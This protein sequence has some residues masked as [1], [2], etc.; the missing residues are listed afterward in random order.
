MISPPS[1]AAVPD[2]S[3]EVLEFLRVDFGLRSPAF[4]RQVLDTVHQW[5]EQHEVRAL[6]PRSETARMLIADG[7]DYLRTYSVRNLGAWQAYVTARARQPAAA[8]LLNVSARKTM[9]LREIPALR[10]R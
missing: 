9:I 4:E 10:V 7:W 6:I 1:F 8:A 2:G 5:E 3:L